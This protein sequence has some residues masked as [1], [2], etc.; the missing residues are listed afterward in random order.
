[1]DRARSS[2]R[3]PVVHVVARSAVPSLVDPA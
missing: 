1:V 2:Y 3:I